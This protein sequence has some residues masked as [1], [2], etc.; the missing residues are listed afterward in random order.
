MFIT[1]LN[2]GFKLFVVDINFYGTFEQVSTKVSVIMIK[3]KVGLFVYS[4]EFWTESEYFKVGVRVAYYLRLKVS[5][6]STKK[7]CSLLECVYSKVKV[8][9]S[10]CKH[11]LFRPFSIVGPLQ[12][13]ITND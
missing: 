4:T 2:T 5:S 1:T 7:S 6:M 12:L 3:I 8:Q 13:S 9:D 11:T 10:G